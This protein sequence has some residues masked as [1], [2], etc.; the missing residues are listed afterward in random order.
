L[1]D[2]YLEGN[3]EEFDYGCNYRECAVLKFY[4]EMGTEKYLPYVC[5]TEL[6]LSNLFRTGLHRT[7]ILYLGGE[8]CDFWYKINRPSTPGLPLEDLPKYKNRRI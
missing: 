5:V 4:Q 3:G 8:Y 7:Q 6:T 1:G 2:G